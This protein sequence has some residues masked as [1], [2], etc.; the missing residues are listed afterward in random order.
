MSKIIES[1]IKKL[2]E[3]QAIENQFD[4]AIQDVCTNLMTIYYD[5]VSKLE[6]ADKSVGAIIKEHLKRIDNAIKELNGTRF[7]R[8][9]KIENEA[10]DPVKKGGKA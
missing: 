9:N 3:L 8:K 5:M 2:Q 7:E 1:K 4:E 6:N 10:A